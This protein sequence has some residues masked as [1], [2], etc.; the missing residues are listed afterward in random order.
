MQPHRTCLALGRRVQ[1]GRRAVGGIPRPA[2]HRPS[3]CRR[4]GGVGRLSPSDA[5]AAQMGACFST[6]A[7]SPLVDLKPSA[8]AGSRQAGARSAASH[9]AP[10]AEPR[11]AAAAAQPPW[12]VDFHSLRLIRRL[13]VGAFGTVHQAVWNDG[14]VAVKVL[15]GGLLA[16]GEQEREAVLAALHRVRW[17]I[18]AR[19]PALVLHDGWLAPAW[20]RLPGRAPQATWPAAP[21]PPLL[22]VAPAPRRTATF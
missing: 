12:L 10:A 22:P 18:G 20:A 4:A 1:E 5:H 16:V 15:S 11:P 14:A 13:G 17:A 19:H 9:T 2:T 8:D 7:P 3:L 6:P 21:A